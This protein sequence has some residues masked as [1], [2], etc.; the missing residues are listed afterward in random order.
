MTEWVVEWRAPLLRKAPLDHP[1]H[2]QAGGSAASWP[3]D[4]PLR[5][6]FAIVLTPHRGPKS[7][8]VRRTMQIAPSL[9]GICAKNALFGT[10]ILTRIGGGANSWGSEGAWACLGS[11][12]WKGPENT[13][14]GSAY[15]RG[16]CF[17][18]SI[19]SNVVEFVPKGLATD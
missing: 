4:H 8:S 7:I 19:V 15:T 3:L 17:W 10:M 1:L 13:T 6:D 5:R 11:D 2:H 9:V 14:E 12:P 16:A 18:S